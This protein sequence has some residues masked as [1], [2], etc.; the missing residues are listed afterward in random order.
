V[1]AE[2]LTT[3]TEL[4]IYHSSFYIL[5]SILG[6]LGISL[7]RIDGIDILIDI[8]PEPEKISKSRLKRGYTPEL[9]MKFL[10]FNSFRHYDIWRIFQRTINVLEINIWN[11]K[12]ITFL[13]N[14][15][16][17]AFARQR[18]AI[19]YKNNYWIYDDLFDPLFD[20]SLGNIATLF[21]EIESNSLIERQDFSIINSFILISLAFSLIKDIADSA[22]IIKNEF[23]L[24]NSYLKNNHLIFNNF[25]STNLF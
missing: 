24:I 16:S 6:L 13:K 12:I 4:N 8:Y 17:L 23:D 25:F 21:V 11:E 9:T 7:P 22:P 10:K 2:D 5:K 1:N 20:G 3:F 19:H 18:N 15:D 14:L